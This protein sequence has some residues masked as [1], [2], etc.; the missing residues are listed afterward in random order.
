MRRVLLSLWLITCCLALWGQGNPNCIE[1]GFITDTHRWGPS[2]D[3]RHAE[4]NIKAFVTYCN[5][6]PEIQFAAFGGDFM[7]SYYTTH[8]QALW[9]LTS[10]RREFENLKVPFYATKGNHD[11]NARVRKPDGTKD[12]SQIITN[13]EF[14][15]IFNPLS[16][17]NPMVDDPEIVVDPEA[18]YAGYYYRDFEEQKFRLIMLNDYDLDSLEVW[19]YHGPQMKW[20]AETALD[21]SE[22]YDAEDWCFIII[23]HAFTFNR[24]DQPIS[25]LMHAYVRG[26][27]FE[28]TDSGVTYHAAYNRQKRASLVAMLGGHNHSDIYSSPDG[29]NIIHVTRGFATDNELGTAE[30][31]FDHFIIDTRNKTFEEHRIGRGKSHVFRY[32]TAEEIFPDLAF[33][34][35]EGMGCYTTGGRDGKILTVTNLNDKGTG[36][37]RWAVEQKGC[38]RVIFDVSGVIHLESPLVIENDSISIEGHSSPGQGISI[39]GNDIQILASQVIM[40]YLHVRKGGVYDGDF[41]QS[42]L[43]LDHLSVAFSPASGISVRRA[44]NATVQNCLLSQNALADTLAGGLVAGGFK[45]T[46]Y[47]NFVGGQRNAIVM[48]SAEGENRWMHIVR[49]VVYNWQDHAMSGGGCGGEATIEENYFIPGPATRNLNFL[50]VDPDGTGRY[51]VWKNTVK[52]REGLVYRQSEM[53]TDA[54]GFPYDPIAPD[55]E[56]RAKINPA[57]LPLK[58]EFTHTCLVEAAYDY[59]PIMGSPNPTQLLRDVE[60]S[61][62]CSRQHDSYDASMLQALAE[63]TPFGDS[64]GYI[65]NEIEV[66]GCPN[67]PFV[68]HSHPSVPDEL[69]DWLLERSK[70]NRSIVIL[71]E[72]DAMGSF[73]GYPRLAGY[74]EAIVRD[75][76]SVGVVSLGDFL[77]GNPICDIND[78]R[79]IIDVMRHVGYDAVVLGNNDCVR[80]LGDVKTLLSGISDVPVVTC[81]N[82]VYSDHP[83]SLLF[84]PW[85]MR[86]YD[87]RKVAFV[88]ATTPRVATTKYLSLLDAEGR[89]QFTVT[90]DSLMADQVQRT[91]DA[92]RAAGAQ[93]VILISHISE[94]E[95]F[96][97]SSV[98]DIV[99]ATRDIDAVLDVDMGLTGNKGTLSVK[100]SKGKTV[101]VC[102]TTSQMEGIGKLIIAPDGYIT[103]EIVHKPDLFFKSPTATYLLDSIQSIYH[104][105]LTHEIGE[106]TCDVIAR[107]ARYGINNRLEDTSVGDLVADALRLYSSAQIGILNSGCVDD[108]I[109]KGPITREEIMK[110]LPFNNMIS[111]VQLSGA[112]ILKLLDWMALQMPTKAKGVLLNVSGM[113]YT[114]RQG[115][116]VVTA[117]VLNPETG[118]YE[119]IDPFQ[120]YSVGTVDYLLYDNKLLDVFQHCK[121]EDDEIMTLSEALIHYIEKDLN[122]R[123]TE[124]YNKPQG[125]INLK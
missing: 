97:M 44:E 107:S 1:F 101:L 34:G 35:A 84:E 27:E 89:Q 108:G 88:G 68:K 115:K 109:K 118:Q 114:V 8:S 83:D 99:K 45:C 63:E 117:E 36:S 16:P 120:T 30:L 65:T 50:D 86:E 57:A 95:S 32:G 33:K 112:K 20:L 125:R 61:I 43:M 54:P 104:N 56:Q 93:Y 64:R 23:G 58:G 2:N 122:G 17:T 98:V 124:P 26:E 91:C 53:V 75:T 85:I 31:A 80:N 3:S 37:L 39:E 72:A 92:A 59:R 9:C 110:L 29:Y 74:R 113:H 111:R 76:A 18:P 62:G 55:L 46:F 28:D 11:C 24:M 19:G 103:N 6:H 7:N 38:R 66:G 4:S 90:S 22:K 102:S 41:G 10:A 49:N 15:D 81:C 25:R 13:R 52:G 77:K 5:E 51:N 94:N 106:A 67:L 40:R 60:F 70:K 121:H 12:N 87:G 14:Y 69:E 48:P 78:G 42:N 119:P 96:G 73:D 79:Y 82:I 105:Y 47:H 123:V 116:G 71:Y 21:F 100:N